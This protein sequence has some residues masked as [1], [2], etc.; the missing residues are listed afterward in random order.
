MRSESKCNNAKF[1]KTRVGY[2][3]AEYE[4]GVECAVSRL[5]VSCKQSPSLASLGATDGKF[6]IQIGSDWPQ[7]GQIWD[8]LRSVSV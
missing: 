6:A 3:L 5:H 2:I 4:M 1:K 8:F 7:I